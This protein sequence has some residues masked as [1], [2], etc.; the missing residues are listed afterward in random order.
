V[1]SAAAPTPTMKLRRPVLVMVMTRSLLF[2]L[3]F[4]RREMW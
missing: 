3:F 4:E 2:W 1:L